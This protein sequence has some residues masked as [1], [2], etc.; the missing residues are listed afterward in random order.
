MPRTPSAS[1]HKKVL[2]AAILL[3]AK[4]GIE[5]TSMDAI[6]NKSGVSKATI[7]KHWADKDALLLEVMAVVNGLD[8]RPSFDS[9]NTQSDLINVLAYRPQQHAEAREQI[10][11]HF[12][13]YSA[14]NKEVGMA[15]RNMVMDPPR[16]ELKHLL[17]QAIRK[18]EI[19]PKLDLDLSLALLLG[20]IL[21]WFI[22]F[23][24]AEKD[25]RRIAEGVVHAFW[26]AFSLDKSGKRGS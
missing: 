14:H 11:P 21:Y 25:P 15:W 9:G 2:D 26:R 1:A 5:T 12:M 20:P 13:A 7:Y 8:L 16:R 3:I 4:Q 6:A 19:T 10:M 22:F 17:K 18:R 24:E 23:R